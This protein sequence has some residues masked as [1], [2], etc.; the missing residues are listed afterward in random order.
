VLNE[1]TH[2]R[3]WINIHLFH[4][5]PIH[6]RLNAPVELS[7]RYATAGRVLEVGSASVAVACMISL[8][9]KTFVTIATTNG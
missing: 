6:C 8:D 9:R 5:R 7:T 3:Q 4:G 1:L 2:S